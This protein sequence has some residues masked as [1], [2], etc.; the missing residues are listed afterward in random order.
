MTWGRIDVIIIT[1][2]KDA[3][4]VCTWESSWNCPPTP[5]LVHGK[6]SSMKLDL[7]PRRL[8]HNPRRIPRMP[9]SLWRLV[10]ASFPPWYFSRISDKGWSKDALLWE[11]ADCLQL[12]KECTEAEIF[13]PG[14]RRFPGKAIE[15]LFIKLCTVPVKDKFNLDISALA[16]CRRQGG[17]LC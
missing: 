7:V 14:T 8:D 6:L 12:G 1:E 9:A 10:P 16:G 11:A 5:T 2:K 15:S 17:S 13:P 3:I 4:H